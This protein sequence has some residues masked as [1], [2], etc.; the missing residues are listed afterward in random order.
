MKAYVLHI[1]S[2]VDVVDHRHWP[3]PSHPASCSWKVV[4]LVPQLLVHRQGPV[5]VST[6]M[7]DVVLSSYSKK[8]L[9]KRLEIQFVCDTMISFG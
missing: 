5:L 2:V 1:N 4:I 6:L 9:S 8:R 3:H 7:I